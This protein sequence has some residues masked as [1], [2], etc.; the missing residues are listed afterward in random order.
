MTDHT[1]PPDVVQA[2]RVPEIAALIAASKELH[3]DMLERSRYG[4]DVI[5][6]Q[7]YKIVN[8]GRTAWSDFVAALHAL[9]G[10]KP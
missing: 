3:R 2:A 1:P 10:D 8:A 4:M 9:G 7:Q 6:G 5:H